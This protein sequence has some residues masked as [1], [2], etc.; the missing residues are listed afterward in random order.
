MGEGAGNNLKLG[1][2]GA[3]IVIYGEKHIKL[4]AFL[5]NKRLLVDS[6][7]RRAEY[8]LPENS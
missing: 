5:M 8:K 2:T 3:N 1:V 4:R 6:Y 7:I